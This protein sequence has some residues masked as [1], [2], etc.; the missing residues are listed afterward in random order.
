MHVTPERLSLF[1]RRELGIWAPLLASTLETAMAQFGVTDLLQ[2]AHFLGQAC[3]ETGGFLKF[4]ENLRYT[5][6]ALL[7]G[8]FSAV[9]GEADAAALIR[10]GPEAIA[11]RVYAGRNGNGDEESGDG[12]KFRGR[13]CFQLTGRA[14]YTAASKSLG[15][16]YVTDPDQV[17]QPV[18]AI[19]TALN[20]WKSH[21]C[22]ALAD[23][24]DCEAV[25]H[26][27]NG[28]GLIGLADRKNLTER[29]KG[30]FV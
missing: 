11:N 5:T 4:E 3:H 24:D 7:A 26:V 30:I 8:I 16:D 28:A 6:P 12:W 15:H 13:G 21:G 27:I 20:F 23:A 1:T 2:R 18:G 19:L 10:K 17:A 9:H 14:N 25:T 29:A 22:N